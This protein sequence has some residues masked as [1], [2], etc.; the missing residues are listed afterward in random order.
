MRK[1]RSSHVKCDC[2]E[3]THKCAH[4]QPTVEGHKETCCCNHGGR[5][6]CSI[7]KEPSLDPVPESES[8][9]EPLTIKPKAATSSNSGGGGGISRRRRANTSKSESLLSLDENGHHKPIHKHTRPSQNCGPY[10]LQRGATVH[11]TGT[12]RTTRS[13]D[14][15]LHYGKTTDRSRTTTCASDL[16]ARRI[17][18]E[19]ASPLMGGNLSFQQ[20]NGQLPPLDLSN[21]QYSQFPSPFDLFS[22][23]GP[24]DQD[25]PMFSAGL[26]AT[27]F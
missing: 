4:L 10:S 15:L 6:T 16:E 3:K 12:G 8:E 14:N 17:K 20:L 26:S 7:K 24:S 22:S 23:S 1:S 11:G 13:V 25:P 5:C 27:S 19:Q 21:I 9:A 2:G 18:S